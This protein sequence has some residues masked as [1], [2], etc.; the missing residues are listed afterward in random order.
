MAN[1]V[2]IDEAGDGNGHF[3]LNLDLVATVKLTGTQDIRQILSDNPKP[4]RGYLRL[5]SADQLMLASFSLDT[6]E[7]AKSWVRQHLGVEL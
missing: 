6:M 7:D 1:F 4:P 3:M 5:E 2:R